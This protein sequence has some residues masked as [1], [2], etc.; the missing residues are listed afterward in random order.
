M[1]RRTFLGRIVK[2]LSALI[3]GFFFLPVWEFLRTFFGSSIA[4][5]AYPIGSVENLQDEVT[6]VGFTRLI[7]DGWRIRTE[8]DYVWVRK[9]AEGAFLAFEPHCTHLGCAFNWEEKSQ[10]FLCPCH[11]GKF[12][13]DGKRVAGPPPRNLDQFEVKLQNGQLRIGKLLKG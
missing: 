7:R 12:N 5:A 1:D 2:A 3:A 9:T 10:L 11:G 8:Q 6:K 4:E 13:K